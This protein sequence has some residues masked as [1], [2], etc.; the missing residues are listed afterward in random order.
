[1]QAVPGAEIDVEELV[2]RLQAGAIVVDVREPD[3]YVAGHVPSARPIPL[4][5]VPERIDEIP[6][7][8]P[9]LVICASGGR[10]RRAADFLIEQGVDAVNV[11]GGTRGWIDSGRAV[12]TGDEPG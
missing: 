11:A 10:S 6:T 8:V 5:D 3:E 2:A 1:M 4:M 9:V 12:V 7:D